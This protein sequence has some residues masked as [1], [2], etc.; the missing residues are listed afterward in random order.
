[1]ENPYFPFFY[2]ITGWNICFFGAGKVAE[3]RIKTLLTYPCKIYIISKKATKA[4]KEMAQKGMVIWVQEEIKEIGGKQQIS[5]LWKTLREK[6]QNYFSK[7]TNFQIVF[8]CTDK[9]EINQ[10]VYE[11]CKEQKIEVNIADCRKQSDFYFPGLLKQ[12][13]LVIGVTGNGENH[14]KVKHSMEMLRKLFM[15]EEEKKG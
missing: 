8:A 5:E 7:E 6:Y 11:Y 3:Q 15:K 12:E 14:K 9:R 2:D 1:M 4:I 13:D 10:V